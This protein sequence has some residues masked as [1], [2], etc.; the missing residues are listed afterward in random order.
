MRV[1]TMLVFNLSRYWQTIFSVQ[2]SSG[3]TPSYNTYAYFHIFAQNYSIAY[4]TSCTN[5]SGDCVR[6]MLT[7]Q[8]IAQISSAFANVTQIC[9]SINDTFIDHFTEFAKCAS[10]PQCQ[11]TYMTYLCCHYISDDYD[12]LYTFAMEHVDCVQLGVVLKYKMF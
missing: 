8:E 11:T 10:R 9:V 12:K 6:D 1:N 3:F 7:K 4:H 2:Y 5:I